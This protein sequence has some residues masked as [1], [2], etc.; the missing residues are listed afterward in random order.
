MKRP[1]GPRIA[2]FVVG[3]V[4]LVVF[5]LTWRYATGWRWFSVALTSFFTVVALATSVGKFPKWAKER[6][7]SFNTGMSV[8]A[9]ALLLSMS[10]VDAIAADPNSIDYASIGCASG[11]PF[12][13]L[14]ISLFIERSQ[15]SHEARVLEA[16]SPPNEQL[17]SAHSTNR[18]SS[19]A[20]E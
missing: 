2:I 9:L 1:S 17:A 13:V 14:L 10:V 15:A 20:A 16:T 8:A 11:V 6:R 19:T 18:G 4:S 12:V 3:T 7:D 5:Y